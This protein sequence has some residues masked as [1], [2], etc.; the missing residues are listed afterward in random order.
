MKTSKSK[1]SIAI[2]GEG[3]TEWFYFD[4]L[5]SHCRY[6][7]K[8]APDFPQHADI[9][10]FIKMAQQYA[11]EGY[12][13]IVCLID[14]DRILA[15][16]TEMNTYHTIRTKTEKAYDNIEFIETN[17]CTEFWFLLHFLPTLQRKYYSSYRDLE[18]ELRLYM[19]GYEKTKRYFQRTK[20][21]HYLAVHGN[22]ELAKSNSKRLCE[23]AS[24]NATDMMAYSQIYKVFDII[25][26]FI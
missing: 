3:E 9:A 12:D 11:S 14:M 10:H 26:S 6:Q 24:Q 18:A 22:L 16:A 4:S 21:Y 13:K 15:N 19:P 8:I 7:F 25:E 20:L 23:I 1:K 5:R 17:P 2:I